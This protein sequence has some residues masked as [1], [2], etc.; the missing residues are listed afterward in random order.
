MVL[1][2]VANSFTTGIQTNLVDDGQNGAAFPMGS[3]VKLP[4]VG[5]APVVEEEADHEAAR[6]PYI[7]VRPPTDGDKQIAN[8]ADTAAIGN[9]GRRHWGHYRRHAN[10]LPRYRQ[11]PP[12]GR[13]AHAA[14]VH[15]H[16]QHLLHN[17]AARRHCKGIVWGSS[18]GFPGII[19][20]NRLVLRCLRVEQTVDD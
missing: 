3:M 1:A 16:G 4:H 15:I 7:H 8:M 20:G 5:G 9:V 2:R 19:L 13:P 18:A 10:A 6:P 14:E 11:D 12:A 17:M